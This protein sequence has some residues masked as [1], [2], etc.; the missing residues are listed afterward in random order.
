VTLITINQTNP[1]VAF[2]YFVTFISAAV[3]SV[4]LFYTV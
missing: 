1:Q 3:A 4:D 2:I